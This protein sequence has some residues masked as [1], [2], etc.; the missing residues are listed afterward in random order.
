[1]T[2]IA[3]AAVGV[4]AL[5]LV[6]APAALAVI[7]IDHGISGVRISNT[8]AQVRASLGAPA[9]QKTGS[10]D[11]GRYVQYTYKEGIVVTFQ[12]EDRVSSISTSGLGDRTAK[13]VGV[14][15]TEAEVKSGVPGVK[16]E[17]IA[18][19]RSCHTGKFTA[20]KKITD[21]SIVNGVVS[22]VTVGIVLD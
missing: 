19:S 8:R 17:T 20:G 7:Q 1:M 15:S 11:F 3:I 13:G 18:A 6:Q 9:K 14:G 10:N 12:G 5:A 2:R 16:C 22:G 21:F 4:C